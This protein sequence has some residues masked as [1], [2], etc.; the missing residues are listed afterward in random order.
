MKPLTQQQR[1]VLAF[2]ESHSDRQGYPPTLREIGEAVDL[3]NLNA[4]RGH[5]A[6]LEKKGYISKAPDKARSIRVLHSPS[7]LSRFKRKLHQ[8]ARTDEG[9]IHRVVYALGWT[10]WR[11]A[12]LLNGNRAKWLA[13]A[14]EREAVEHGWT[15]MDKTIR[16]DRVLLT[17]QAWPNHSPA[18][19]VRRF[20]SSGNA[21]KRRR[22]KEFPAG[23]L[24]GNG[25]A[26]TTDP[27][28]LDELLSRLL[29]EQTDQ[30]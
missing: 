30:R 4:V 6:A 22:S 26:V 28:L 11:L 17:V 9:V 5:L 29:E 15:L 23:R 24:W 3:V 19:V 7:A 13:A 27:E 2:V 12:P 14:F 8:L 20:Q 18:L 21:L 1:K 16:P 25:F 10:T